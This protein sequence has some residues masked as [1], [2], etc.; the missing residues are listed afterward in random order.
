MTLY[1]DDFSVLKTTN[2]AA[3]VTSA[4]AGEILAFDKIED[5]SLVLTTT[6]AASYPAFYAAYTGREILKGRKALCKLPCAMAQTGST[7]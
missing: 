3:P 5:A 4:A 6:A 7:T 2:K 1:F